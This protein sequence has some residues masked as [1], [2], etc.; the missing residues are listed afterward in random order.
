MVSVIS[1]VGVFTAATRTEAEALHAAAVRL[2]AAR[3]A[4]KGHPLFGAGDTAAE[5]DEAACLVARIHD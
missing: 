3:E 2:A 5:A 1:S 4:S